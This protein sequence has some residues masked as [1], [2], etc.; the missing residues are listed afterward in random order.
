MWTADVS[1]D[2]PGAD[3]E[4]AEKF[5]TFVSV[6]VLGAGGEEVIGTLC[7]AGRSRRYLSDRAISEV[8]RMSRGISDFLARRGI[9]PLEGTVTA[10][11]G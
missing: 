3:A 8:E 7:A 11:G 1:R 2:L 6:P 4:D 5:G 9:D 10:A